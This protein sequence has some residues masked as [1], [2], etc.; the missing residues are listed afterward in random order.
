MVKKNTLYSI[1]RKE[2][3]MKNR[4]ILIITAFFLVIDITI[5][6]STNLIKPDSGKTKKSEDDTLKSNP[7]VDIRVNKEYDDN[8]NIIRYDSTYSYIYTYPDGS[9]ETLNADSLFKSFQPYFFDRSFE[10]MRD[11]FRDFFDKD[12]FYE[13]HFFEQNYFMQQFE[14]EKFRFD[15]MIKKMDSLR[16][17]FL[18]QTYPNIQQNKDEPAKKKTGKIY[19]I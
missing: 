12:T 2:V 9:K 1:K 16:N 14:R 5:G 7:K 18:K 19:E 11:P 10:I 15:E 6:F 13:K 4:K 8:G 3:I 17:R